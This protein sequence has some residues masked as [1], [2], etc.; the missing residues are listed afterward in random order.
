MTDRIFPLLPQDPQLLDLFRLFPHAVQPLLDY[1]DRLLR[2]ES[3]LTV[4]EREPIAAHVPCLN[5]CD[6]CHG[7]H[8]IAASVHGLDEGLFAAMR[9]DAQGRLSMLGLARDAIIEDRIV[10]H[11][12]PKVD[13]RSGRLDGFEALLRWNHPS[14][15][16]Q[17]PNTIAAAFQ[18]GALAAEIS[19]RMIQSVISDMRRWTDAGIHFGHVA[20]NAAAA[21]FKSGNFAEKLLNELRQANLPTSCLQLEVTETVFL[22]RGAEHVENTLRA[23]SKEGIQIALDDFGTGYASLSHLNNFPVNV[24]KVDR[25]FIRKLETSDRDAAIVRAVIKLGRSLNIKIVAE[26]IETQRQAEFLRKHRCHSGQGYLF[27]KAVPAAV[28]PSLVA[29]WGK[30]HVAA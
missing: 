9:A 13:L 7:A 17:T 30:T 16:L 5:A 3:P 28:V 23:L 15:G 29:T 11:Y 27:G 18:D 1:H 8:I 22:G 10:A 26:G 25:S 6:F 14:K 24:I 2:D 20:V 4:G 19:D 12:Q 21:E